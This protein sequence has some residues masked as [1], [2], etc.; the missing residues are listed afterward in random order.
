VKPENQ[1]AQ[2]TR[3]DEQLEL[4][5]F[6]SLSPLTSRFFFH[7]HF[8][9]PGTISKRVST[10]ITKW[11]EVLADA[12]RCLKPGAWVELSETGSKSRKSNAV[13]PPNFLIRI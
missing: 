4:L 11:P 2:D 8:V 10:G 3:T 13:P 9:S 6:H 7:T 1:K 5:R 12:Y